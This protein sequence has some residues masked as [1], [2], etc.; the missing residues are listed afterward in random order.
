MVAVGMARS[1]AQSPQAKGK[2]FPPLSAILLVVPIFAMTLVV[3]A[4]LNSQGWTITALCMAVL[5]GLAVLALLWNDLVLA[6]GGLFLCVACGIMGSSL[7]TPLFGRTV[8]GIRVADA[9][10]HSSAAIFHFTDGHVVSRATRWVPVYGGTKGT[11]HVLY[12]LGVAPI[13]G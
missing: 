5:A 7:E 1:T 9:P 12:S 8:T 11:D 6:F 3:C 4:V 10:A 13:A 2:P